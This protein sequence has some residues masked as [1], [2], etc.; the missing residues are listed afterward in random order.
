ML[1]VWKDIKG[2]DGIYQVSNLGRVRSVARTIIYAN[3]SEH[4]TKGYILK[5][6]ISNCGYCRVKLSKGQNGFYK[7]VH[8]LV[9]EAFIPNSE[10]KQQV[11]HKN[12]VKTDNRVENLE[13]CTC[14]E[15]NLHKF[16]V[17]KRQNPLLNRKGK[18]YPNIRIIMQ[19]KDDKIIAEYYGAA[20]ASRE[21]GICASGISSACNKKIKHSGGY[22]WE[23]KIKRVK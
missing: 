9:A 14:S 18:L 5:P 13:F 16:R 23:Y 6:R 4:Y 3:G 17:L 12:G 8:R 19:I 2:F 11:N 21:T 15:N 22:K 10:N 1:E 20:E 7:S